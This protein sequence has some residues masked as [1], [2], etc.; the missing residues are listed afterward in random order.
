MQIYF[1]A[2]IAGGRAYLATYEKIVRH[3][4]ALGHRVLTEH[5]IAP[6]V[7]DQESHLTAEEIYRRD[8]EW[9]ADCDA[10]VAEISNPSLGVGYEIAYALDLG[11]KILALHQRGLFI[12]RMIIGN[13]RPGLSIA[14]YESDAEWQKQ[15]DQFLG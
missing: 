2:S 1:A 7:L 4:Q 9:L 14:D 8:V 6:D 10:L 3:L 5:I 13:P 12:S 11:K 15:I